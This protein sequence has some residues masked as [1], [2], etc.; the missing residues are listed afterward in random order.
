MSKNQENPA[1]TNHS[2]SATH[3]ILQRSTTLSRK[4]VKKPVVAKKTVNSSVVASDIISNMNANSIITK[5]KSSRLKKIKDHTLKT[6]LKDTDNLET[7]PELHPK[8]RSK[9]LLLALICSTATVGAIAAFVYFNMPDISVKVTAMQSGVDATYP[10][11]VP[12]NYQLSGVTSQKDGKIT[13][14]FTNTSTED[15]FTLTEETS[16]WD[17]NALL[18]NYVKE[19]YNDNYTTL[20]EQG[21]T[22]YIDS[23]HATWV[24][25]GTRFEL[26]A[27]HGK[28]LSKE[29]IRNLVISL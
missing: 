7:S 21:I 5:Q 19:K 10:S 26:A 16:T 15:S 3:N 9:R 18:T 14:V 8:K 11:Y 29:Q 17:S 27:S 4:Y 23:E 13:M 22:V 28:F 20:R 6:A 12:R 1:K 2:S 24:N 25:G